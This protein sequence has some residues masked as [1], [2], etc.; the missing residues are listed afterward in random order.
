MILVTLPESALFS[1]LPR[2]TLPALGEKPLM[3]VILTAGIAL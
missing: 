1:V 2:I 3:P